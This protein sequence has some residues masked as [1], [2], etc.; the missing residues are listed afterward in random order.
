MP[1]DSI[2]DEER[3]GDIN[4]VP[5][6]RVLRMLGNIEF[7]NWQCLAE[8]IDNSIDAL[9]PRG[10]GTIVIKTPSISDFDN[11]PGAVI[12][13]WDNGPGMT[14]EDLENALKAGY[15]G[16]DLDPLSHLGLFGMGFNI[17]TARLGSTTQV[18]T[19]REG[20]EYWTSVI[21]NFKEME[22]SNSYIRPLY[23]IKKTN[24]SIHGTSII[25]S[26][27]SE[28]V[29]TF[30][31]QSN[32]KK[33]LS[34][35]YAPILQK[36]I[37]NI[38]INEDKLTSRGHCIWGDNRYVMRDGEK[39]YAKQEIDHSFGTD[40]YCTNCWEWIDDIS[41]SR[42]IEKIVCPKCGESSGVIQKERRL[43]GWIGVQRYYDLEHYGLDLIR[44]GRVIEESC[45][46]LFYWN[47]PETGEHE[48]EYPIEAY[49]WGGRIVGELNIDFV[50]LTY[51]KDH[52]EKAD[53][54]WKEVERFVRGEGPFRP[55]IAKR[56]GY[57]ENHSPLGL[58]Y[59]GYR[60]GNDAGYGDL[61][62][63]TLDGK[64]ELTGTNP[65]P[66]LW[67]EKYYEGEPEYQDD[68]KWWD[69][70]EFAERAKRSSGGSTP[71]LP[72]P[73][74]QKHIKTIK[75]ELKGT[76]PEG[77]KEEAIKTESDPLLTQDYELEELKEPP[78]SVTVNKSVSGNHDEMP[79]K[80]TVKSKDKFEVIY[81]PRHPIFSGF[82]IEPLDLILLELS[83]T[84]SKR[85]DD[86]NEW[87]PSRV[88]CLLKEKYSLDKKLS[89]SALSGKASEL[90]SSIKRH[91]VTKNVTFDTGD[92]SPQVIDEVR[93]NVLSRIGGGE[94]VVHELL[95]TTKYVSYAPDEEIR[96]ILLKKPEIF[97]EGE[98]WNRPYST[99]G[100]KPLQE[101][102]IRTFLGYISDILWLKREA[103]DYDPDAMSND[104]EY[105]LQRAA[106]SLKLLEVYSE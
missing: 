29:R 21:I 46:D 1:G 94:D 11:N 51:M 34:R 43:T 95:A 23:R 26:D 85:K 16:N 104:I 99:L 10:G 37:F 45:K 71:D 36:G 25:I 9:L 17:A 63:G 105:R 4:L 30:R 7:E 77:E 83:Q 81:N 47:N 59:K 19:S 101:D 69:L 40:Y 6:P 14:P 103:N 91:I 102:I 38:L 98:Y 72:K 2:G 55:Q 20:D 53:K 54:R 44:N 31:H 49:H 8:L 68:T 93:K 80:L 62:P 87:P 96:N 86:P 75:P 48:K 13:V 79:V 74:D 52:F 32:L 24:R 64:G 90:I 12:I 60:K 97:F 92:I 28:R 73:A 78:I 100:S 61:L 58:M 15:S 56:H 70:V 22:K 41:A 84:L 67:A 42:D 89:P 18:K 27:L 88:F 57:P 65:T 3:I 66:K 35:I 106:Y 50:P 76:S 5:S 33:K 39:N 82:N